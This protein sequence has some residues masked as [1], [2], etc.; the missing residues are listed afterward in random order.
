MAYSIP[1][2]FM[3]AFAVGL[4]FAL[5]YEALRII[6][7]LLPFRAVT[8]VCDVL[9]FVLAAFAVTKLSLVLGNYIRGYTVLGFGAGVF[10]Y[11]TTIGRLINRLENA[12]SDAIRA[13]LGAFFGAAGKLLRSVFGF[14]AHNISDV[15]GEINK[16]SRNLLKTL[17]KPLQ[18][19]PQLVYNNKSNNLNSRGSES[20]NVIRA[21][22][23][24][25][26]NA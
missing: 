13:V 11:I 14:I 15:F 4:L 12:V 17:H 26:G 22:V 8:F 6:R 5:V 18:K 23:K 10:T 19:K 21:K 16:I 9:F 25:S 2:C 3:T 1:D 7:I 20:Q 24:R